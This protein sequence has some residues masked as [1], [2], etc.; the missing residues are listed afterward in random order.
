MNDNCLAKRP[1]RGDHSMKRSSNCIIIVVTVII[2]TRFSY[3]H[4]L[5]FGARPFSLWRGLGAVRMYSRIPSLYT[6]DVSSNSRMFLDI[7]KYPL[8]GG[9]GDKIAP[10]QKPLI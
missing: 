7:A 8:K 5:T 9:E 10:G 6:L 1:A 4:T 2:Q 3:S